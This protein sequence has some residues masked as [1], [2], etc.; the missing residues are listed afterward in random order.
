MRPRF[1]IVL[2]FLLFN[3]CRN[4]PSLNANDGGADGTSIA[5]KN[6]DGPA[7]S[8]PSN[9]SPA[10]VDVSTAPADAARTPSGLASKIL[11]PGSDKDRS[12]PTDKVNG[13]LHRLDQG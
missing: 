5:M 2:S 9:E 7:A 11:T 10:P 4:A 12:A 8:G 13:K 1:S 6:E 3:A